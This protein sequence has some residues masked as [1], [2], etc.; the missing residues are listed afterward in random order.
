MCRTTARSCATK[1]YDR[2]EFGSQS[3]EQVDD[4]GADRDVERRHRF[5]EHQQLRARAR[6]RERCRCA[7]AARPR[8]PAGTG[9][10]CSGCRP[11]SR[12]RS[13]HPARAHRGAGTPWAS[14]GS[15]EMSPTGSRG[16]SDAIGSWNTT[17]RSR[18]IANRSRGRQ[19]RGVRGRARHAARLRRHEVQDLHDRRRLAA[20][21]LADQPERFA[22]ADVEADAVHRVHACRRG[23][24][25][26]RPSVSGN[27]LTR[28]RTSS[29]VG[30]GVHA[31]LASRPLAARASRRKDV[32]ARHT[33]RVRFRRGDGR[34]R[35][36]LRRTSRW[37]E[38]RSRSR[39]LRRCASGSAARTGSPAAGPRATADCPRSASAP[40][41]RPRPGR[42]SDPS[43]PS[44]YGIRGR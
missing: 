31:A 9:C 38:R 29:T 1:R 26:R 16:S 39:A 13:A 15:A 41:A 23:G 4:A 8:T 25:A 19:R 32:G 3:F 33:P 2:P 10:A 14:S 30:A 12:S 44:V 35:R 5:V 40:D 18:R 37:H 43:R 11:T 36:G 20:A 42:G 17:C 7:G 22:F 27:S 6:A 28:S 21:G 24:G 34:P